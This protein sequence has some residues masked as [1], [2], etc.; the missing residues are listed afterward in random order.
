MKPSPSN[1]PRGLRGFDVVED[2]SFGF[3]QRCN[4]N[5]MAWFLYGRNFDLERMT[6]RYRK[7]IITEIN[8][9]GDNHYHARDV[10]RDADIPAFSQS[11]VAVATCLLALGTL[12]AHNGSSATQLLKHG[13]EEHVSRVY[14]T[15]MILAAVRRQCA[16]IAGCEAA[17]SENEYLRHALIEKKQQ[18]TRLQHT[19]QT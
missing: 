13:L 9:I 17:L 14:G 1:L 3:I 10:D 11:T 16:T 7:Q 6:K 19:R 12:R 15:E 4:G 2:G 18:I 5:Q 8:I